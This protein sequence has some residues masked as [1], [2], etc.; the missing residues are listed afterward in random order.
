MV[1]PPARPPVEWREEIDPDWVAEESIA[2]VAERRLCPAIS[3][4]AIGQ[5]WEGAV[6]SPA[7]GGI[8][9]E[10]GEAANWDKV[11]TAPVSGVAAFN[12]VAAATVLDLVEA[13]NLDRV[14]TVPAEE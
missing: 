1:R 13:A 5:A 8:V 11:E 9:R 3:E 6:F 10:L 2:P 14:E 4:V 7:V 12:Q